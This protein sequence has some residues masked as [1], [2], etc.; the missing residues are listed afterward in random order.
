MTVVTGGIGMIQV[1]AVRAPVALDADL[2]RILEVIEVRRG[3]IPVVPAVD[4][5]F[6]RQMFNR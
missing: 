4:V 3:E 2:S 1:D 5:A 6:G